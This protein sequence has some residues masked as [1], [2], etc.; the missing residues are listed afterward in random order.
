M[1]ITIFRN[2]KGRNHFFPCGTI[3]KIYSDFSKA[4][5]GTVGRCSGTKSLTDWGQAQIEQI[6][7]FVYSKRA[8]SRLNSFPRSSPL[9][10]LCSSCHVVQAQLNFI[11]ILKIFY[12]QE[13][14]AWQPYCTTKK[15]ICYLFGLYWNII[16]FLDDKCK[17]M[18]TMCTEHLNRYHC[19]AWE[20][21]S[22]RYMNSV[23][24]MERDCRSRE[25]TCVII[26]KPIGHA[27]LT[28]SKVTLITV[29]LAIDR[30]VWKWLMCR[31]NSVWTRMM[32]Q[33]KNSEK[34]M[35]NQRMYK[36]WQFDNA[37]NKELK[38]H[39]W[40]NYNWKRKKH[41]QKPKFVKGPGEKTIRK[42]RATLFM[43]AKSP[44]WT[45]EYIARGQCSYSWPRGRIWKLEI[46]FPRSFLSVPVL[47]H[48]YMQIF[49]ALKNMRSLV[50]VRRKLFRQNILCSAFVIGSCKDFRSM[51]S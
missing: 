28:K 32:I 8:A 40:W 45:L 4:G 38:M 12:L 44:N 10:V 2:N 31:R 3:W 50:R 7:G 42:K 37:S 14:R 46:I 48:S 29:L 18:E 49:Q 41:E 9:P 5:P 20:K 43:F 19:T 11:A 33:K 30:T 27:A 16:V 39:I 47:C 26:C 35:R 15:V 22:H 36:C 24:R 1:S 17:S 21:C 13:S 34:T 25:P 51:F 23:S 6:F